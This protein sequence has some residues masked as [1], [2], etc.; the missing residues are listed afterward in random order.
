[1]GEVVHKE[2]HVKLMLAVR[3]IYKLELKVPSCGS[4]C[5]RVLSHIEL[6]TQ[7]LELF[8]TLGAQSTDLPCFGSLVASLCGAGRCEIVSG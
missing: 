5:P 3:Y 1:M 8:R 4:F 6:V 2:G 7:Y